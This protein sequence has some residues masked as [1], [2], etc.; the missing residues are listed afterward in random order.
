MEKITGK[1]TEFDLRQRAGLPVLAIFVP[2]QGNC[3]AKFLCWGWGALRRTL[4]LPW[5]FVRAMEV[6]RFRSVFDGY[7]ICRF[8]CR[9]FAVSGKV[10]QV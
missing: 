2:L 5:I 10:G 8:F 7:T 9:I 1:R 6:L 4:F 3:L